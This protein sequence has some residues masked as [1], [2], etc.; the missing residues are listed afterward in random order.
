MSEV[1]VVPSSLS[2]VEPIDHHMGGAA[3]ELRQ[4]QMIQ[5]VRREVTKWRIQ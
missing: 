3:S 5:L 2:I 4:Q 1:V